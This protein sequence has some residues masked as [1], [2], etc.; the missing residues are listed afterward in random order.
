MFLPL[1]FLLT[2]YVPLVATPHV[3]VSVAPYKYLVERIAEDSVTV[4]LL[5]PPTANVHTYEPTIKEVQNASQAAL[6]FYI[7]ESFEPRV[8]RAFHAHSPSMEMVDLREGL[9]LIA[10][11]EHSHHGCCHPE[12]MDLHI[13]LSPSMMQIQAK[14]VADRL[15]RRYPEHAEQYYRA[16]QEHIEELKALQHEMDLLLKPVRGSTLLVTHPAYAYICRDF[17]LHQ[18]PIE[19]EGKDPSARQLSYLLSRARALQIKK[20]YTQP[21]YSQK[22][23]SLLASQ[24][25][26]SLVELDPYAENYVENLKLLAKHFSSP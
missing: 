15:A 16:L 19:I 23:A 6:W 9:E 13:W 25:K 8:K 5:V 11:E 14:T 22:V 18:L 3:L 12:G 20:I 26:A 7:G 17:S 10:G 1:L 21:Q 2:L 4:E 24:I